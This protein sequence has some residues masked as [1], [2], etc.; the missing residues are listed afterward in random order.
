MKY[1]RNRRKKMKLQ[2]KEDTKEVTM[3]NEKQPTE[4]VNPPIE[5]IMTTQE[6]MEE[7]FSSQENETVNLAILRGRCKFC[8]K[9]LQRLQALND[10][11]SIPVEEKGRF[12]AVLTKNF[13]SSDESMLEAEDS[14]HSSD[15]EDEA[16][17]APKR[18]LNHSETVWKE[19]L[20]HKPTS[21]QLLRP[22][23]WGWNFDNWMWKPFW[24]TQPEVLKS[25]QELIS[26]G[27]QKGCRG[28][29]SCTKNDL[30]C[31]ELCRCPEECNRRSDECG[32]QMKRA[33]THNMY[34]IILVLA[35]ALKRLSR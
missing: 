10:S 6:E 31:K 5:S 24:T 1:I 22:P 29:C 32:R 16:P 4:S 11:N 2:K 35:F 30:R 28:R 17:R 34:E 9:R 26:C 13:V 19:S 23:D 20:E 8:K 14:P 27:C 18:R 21:P 33:P 12:N 7:K 15:S 3:P 25:C